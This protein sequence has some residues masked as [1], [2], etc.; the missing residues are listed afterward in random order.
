M[1]KNIFVLLLGVFMMIFL[2]ACG[3][4]LLMVDSTLSDSTSEIEESS[5]PSTDTRSEKQEQPELGTKKVLVA[6]FSYS[7]NTRE[8]ANQ[9]HKSVGGDFFEI[10]PEKPYPKDYDEVKKQVNKEQQSDYKPMLKSKIKNIQLYDVVF[11]G[12]PNWWGTLPVP[13]KTVLSEYDSYGKIIIPFCIYEGSSLGQS[14]TDISKFC[15]KSNILDGIEVQSK[16]MK[17]AQNDV[18]KWLYKIKIQIAE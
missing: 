2:T 1:K 10:R 13:V 9:I 11:I 3:S 8:I 4:G 16:D 7:G 12:Y 14:V 15:P 6:Y 17:S 18:S 5:V